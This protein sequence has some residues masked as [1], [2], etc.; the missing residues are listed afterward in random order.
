MFRR[1]A[2]AATCVIAAAVVALPS[3]GAQPYQQKVV[4]GW[5]KV[6]DEE[7]DKLKPQAETTIRGPVKPGQKTSYEFTF[8]PGM[9]VHDA[10]DWTA[11]TWTTL[12]VCEDPDVPF[13]RDPT[14]DDV[15]WTGGEVNSVQVVPGRTPGC[16]VALFGQAWDPDQGIV[17]TNQNHPHFREFGF[18]FQ[19]MAYDAPSEIT[20][21]IPATVQHGAD[22]FNAEATIEVGRVVDRDLRTLDEKVEMTGAKNANGLCSYRASMATEFA[23]P[24]ISGAWGYLLQF[25]SSQVEAPPAW[26]EQGRTWRDLGKASRAVTTVTTPEGD[27]ETRAASA[28]QMEPCLTNPLGG[29]VPTRRT[30]VDQIFPLTSDFSSDLWIGPEDSTDVEID[31]TDLCIPGLKVGDRVELDDD[32][33]H[34][35]YRLTLSVS[36][37]PEIAMAKATI[38]AEVK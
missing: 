13:D 27:T 6:G 32:P 5:N 4:P 12:V 37:P 34:P 11:Q 15:S 8:T 29:H 10:G 30:L 38:N 36:R 2:L 7:M 9:H 22:S 23:Q 21:S 1:K 20:L 3:S 31:F 16:W 33:S 18:P 28:E 17:R 24:G 25:D 35:P 19:R 26:K 14:T